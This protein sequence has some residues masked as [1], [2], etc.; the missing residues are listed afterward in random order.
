MQ[1]D[2]R[3]FVVVSVAHP[4]TAVCYMQRCCVIISRLIGKYVIGIA[5]CL[6]R[7]CGQRNRGLSRLR[8]LQLCQN[9]RSLSSARGTELRRLYSSIPLALI[10]DRPLLRPGLSAGEGTGWFLVGMSLTLP[11]ASP[12][13]GEKLESQNM[14]TAVLVAVPSRGQP[15]AETAALDVSTGVEADARCSRCRGRSRDRSVSRGRSRGANLVAALG[16]DLVAVPGVDPA[17]AL[18]EDPVAILEEDP[19]AVLEADL[20]AIL[21]ADLVAILE[22]DLV[23]ILGVDPVATPGVDPVAIPEGGLQDHQTAWIMDVA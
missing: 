22:A 3:K 8:L 14:E 9:G 6:I 15:S 10:N 12:K 18:E 20:V 11:L 7:S 17:V 1:C 5:E 13:T 16:A 4:S 2:L 23:A 21:E 19:V